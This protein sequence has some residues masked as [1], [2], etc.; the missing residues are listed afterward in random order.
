MS[1][2]ESPDLGSRLRELAPPIDLPVDLIDGVRR[3]ARRRVATLAS[4]ATAGV[5]AVVVA[6]LLVVHVV[7]GPA[8]PSGAQL[9][10]LVAAGSAAPMRYTGPGIP[11]DLKNTTLWLVGDYYSAPERWVIVS[12]RKDDHPCL[13]TIDWSTTLKVPRGPIYGFEGG[14]SLGQRIDSTGDYG[15]L[16][17]PG[18]SGANAY[19]FGTVP[20]NVRVVRADVNSGPR[21]TQ[22][23]VATTA[24]PT[25]ST[26]RFFV[27][28]VPG[29]TDRAIDADLT[30]YD[31]NGDAVGSHHVHEGKLAGDDNPGCPP[32]QPG[33]GCAQVSATP[34]S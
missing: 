25:T 5:A 22:R 13:G 15:P 19:L 21:T 24:T 20:A 14:C 29:G 31:V 3:R 9:R 11:A 23:F 10:A 17:P 32:P 16:G 7:V 27:F 12:Y 1:P 2:L 34:P 26:E 28:V 30:Y 4:G 18:M 33:S 6:V 8:G